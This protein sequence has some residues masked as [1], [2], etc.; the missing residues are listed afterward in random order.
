ME[1]ASHRV[2]VGVSGSLGSLQALRRA[3]AEARLRDSVICSVITWVPRGGE[4]ANRRA[5]S[6]GLLR[7]WRDAAAQRL[8]TAWQE[9]LGGIPDDLDA[10]LLALRGA[11]GRSLMQF[12]DRESDLLVV[13]A[14]TGGALR[15][16]VTGSVSR[17]CLSRA[18]CAVLT[19]PPTLAQRKLEHHPLARRRIVR[20]LARHD[21]SCS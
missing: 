15:R 21:A 5:P 8:C 14:G 2:I 7:L 6:P 17:Y 12:A 18:Q 19:V 13:G 9:A 3:V 20:D 10:H 4:A 11:P 1:D 16:L